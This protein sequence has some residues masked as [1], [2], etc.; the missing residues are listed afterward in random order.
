MEEESDRQPTVVD[1]DDLVSLDSEP[2]G[3]RDGCRR[4]EAG[5]DYVVEIS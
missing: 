2:E 4:P 1:E 3:R 5:G